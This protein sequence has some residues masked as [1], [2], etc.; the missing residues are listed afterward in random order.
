MQKI[1]LDFSATHFLLKGYIFKTPPSSVLCPDEVVKQLKMLRLFHRV[2][3]R[4]QN[5][6]AWKLDVY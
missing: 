3:A 5:L 6:G 2:G 4:L 1:A